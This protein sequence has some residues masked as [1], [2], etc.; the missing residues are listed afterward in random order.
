MMRAGGTAVSI[1]KDL[2][3]KV[4]DRTI[5]RR[6]KEIRGPKNVSRPRKIPPHDPNGPMLPRPPSIAPRPA[7]VAARDAPPPSSGELP[8][9][10]DAIPEGT[11]LVTL[12]RWLVT[13]ERMGAAAEKRGDL[14][15]LAA[16][17]RLTAS[18]LEAKRKATPIPRADPNE[19]PDFVAAAT[20]ARALLHRYLDQAIQAAMPQPT[21]EPKETTTWISH[22]PW[23]PEQIRN[24]AAYQAAE[25][26]H[27][28]MSGE[29][30]IL[31]PTADGWRETIDGLVVQT[32]AHAGMLDGSWAEASSASLKRLKPTK[33]PTT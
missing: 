5:S 29:G 28:F 22:A 24:L 14:A 12:E 20:K 13:A 3:G 23:T 1:A 11:D 19:H 6:M 9:S 15:S 27:P 25:N 31:I 17:G 33:E 21:K 30:R 2:G 18:L 10:P 7:P 26:V 16:A 4:T 32:W 8:P